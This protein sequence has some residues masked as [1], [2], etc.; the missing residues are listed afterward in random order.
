[1]T[2]EHPGL[3]DLYDMLRAYGPVSSTLSK[4]VR[5]AIQAAPG[6]IYVWCDWSAI[7]ARVN[8]W[9]AGSDLAYR[10]VLQYFHDG[11]DLYVD[12]AKDIFN[13]SSIDLDTAEGKEQRQSGKIAVLSL[14]FLGSVG[15][16]K[17]MA[18]GY[19]LRLSDEQARKIVDGW[20]SRNTW[21]RAFGDEAWYAFQTCIENPG[22][23][24]RAGRLEFKYDANL[25]GGTV[26]TFLPSGR[27]LCYPFIKVGM[28]ENQDGEEEYMITYK[29][30][31]GR[32]RAWAGK[33]IQGPTQACAADMLRLAIMKLDPYNVVVGHTHDELLIEV[34]EDKCDYWKAKLKEIMCELPPWADED[35]PIAA[36]VESDFYYHK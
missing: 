33:M 15:A 34:D 19:G 6:K 32:A 14:G 5:P 21:A 28:Q 36:E 11:A 31:H 29:H 8:P 30:G 12:N 9:L 7:E 26:L 23:T 27:P 18:R 16:L 4:L 17:A 25:M 2:P 22:A 24:Y 13:V 20:R 3:Q 1:M 10:Q 35:L